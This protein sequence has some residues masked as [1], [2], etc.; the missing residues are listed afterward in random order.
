M[1][2]LATLRPCPASD[3]ARRHRAGARV[4]KGGTIRG[5]L[6]CNLRIAQ[7]SDAA[8]RRPRGACANLVPRQAH[9]AAATALSV[10]DSMAPDAHTPTRQAQLGVAGGDRRAYPPNSA[11][12]KAIGQATTINATERH[13]SPW[14]AGIPASTLRQA[15]AAN[16]STMPAAQ[17]MRS[18]R[19]QRITRTPPRAHEDGGGQPECPG[20]GARYKPA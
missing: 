8:L 15:I 9:Q 18:Q 7:R 12:S 19:H 11:A 16:V 5:R 1:T 17:M 10:A 2:R 14:N 3:H 6:S 20:C 13:S 4:D